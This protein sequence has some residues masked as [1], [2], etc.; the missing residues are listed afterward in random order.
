MERLTEVENGTAMVKGCG[1]NCKYGFQHCSKEDWENCKTIDD[2]IDKLAE[3]EDL[4]DKLN[5]IS[6][7]QVVD[8]FVKTVEN[9][10]CEKYE[11]GRI[12]TNEEADKWNEYKQLEEQDL[13][14]RL[15]CKVGDTIYRVNA[16]AKEPV[17]KMRVLQ[18]HYKQ[19]H[20]DRIIIRID[21]INDNDMGE[22]C[23]LLEDIGKTVFL[24][25]SEAEQKLKEMES[26]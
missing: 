22:S 7:K 8:G 9:Q 23:Y 4:E 6:V 19:L 14:L 18:V 17:I 1:S 2:L 16:G 21:A 10:T 25:K 26:D 15:P 11:H 20:K 12:L 24:T 13:L 3:Y 5:G